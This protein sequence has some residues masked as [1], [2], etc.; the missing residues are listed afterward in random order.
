MT[1]NTNGKQPM[2]AEQLILKDS[3]VTGY[4]SDGGIV[5]VPDG[6]TSVGYRAFDWNHNLTEVYLPEGVTSI[7]TDA[8][9]GCDSMVRIN[10]PDSLTRIGGNAL[11]YIAAEEIY[12]V[13]I[14]DGQIYMDGAFYQE[15]SHE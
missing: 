6:V 11:R 12:T 5:T 15:V 4:T 7:G 13:E 3:T 8:F 10:L 1:N 2:V 9:C 14:K